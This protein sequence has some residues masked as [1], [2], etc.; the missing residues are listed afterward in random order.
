MWLSEFGERLLGFLNSDPFLDWFF[1]TLPGLFLWALRSGRNK[2]RLWPKP[3][4]PITSYRNKSDKMLKVRSY[5]TRKIGL[6]TMLWS[7]LL[8]FVVADHQQRV[9]L[10]GLGWFVLLIVGSCVVIFIELTS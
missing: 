6:L 4:W 2:K 3:A 10:Y 5:V 9:N 7:L 1:M 8:A